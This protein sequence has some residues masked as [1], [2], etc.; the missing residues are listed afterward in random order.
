MF[1]SQKFEAQAVHDLC[2]CCF[3]CML[4]GDLQPGATLYFKFHKGL[5]SGSTERNAITQY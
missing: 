5:G 2:E 1:L 3:I 4:G